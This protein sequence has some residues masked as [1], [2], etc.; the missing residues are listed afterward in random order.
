[1]SSRITSAFLAISIHAAAALLLLAVWRT[2]EAGV[3]GP[4]GGEHLT[5][6]SLAAAPDDASEPQPK[7]ETAAREAESVAEPVASR[8]PSLSLPP[9]RPV[10]SSLPLPRPVPLAEGGGKQGAESPNAASVPASPQASVA[11][12]DDGRPGDASP[13]SEASAPARSSTGNNSYAV[14]VFRHILRKKEFPSRLAQAGIRGR[15]LVRFNLTGAGEIT[16]ILIVKSSGV[17]ALDGLAL[18]QIRGAVPYPR[19]PKELSAAQLHFIVPMT[20]RP[21]T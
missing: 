5:T 4:V 13:A 2:P 3:Q 11:A 18:E 15:V 21:S 6:L 9:L 12:A 1:M 20:Y 14:K 17:A 8:A 10:A 16:D 7:Q 19:P